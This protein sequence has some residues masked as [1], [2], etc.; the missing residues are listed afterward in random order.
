MEGAMSTCD[1]VWALVPELC[2]YQ[3]GT[4]PEQGRYEVTTHGGIVTSGDLL[5]V[6]QEN[7]DGAGGWLRTW[8][9]YRRV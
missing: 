6:M 3:K 9:V 1:G 5:S 2:H 8:Q 4:P 7:A